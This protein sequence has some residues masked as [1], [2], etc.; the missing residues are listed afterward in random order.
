MEN[1]DIMD[2]IEILTECL[3]AGGHT[4]AS[5]CLP[6]TAVDKL[7]NA[8]RYLQAQDVPAYEVIVGNVGTV[9]SGNS[10][11]MAHAV[12]LKYVA[13]SNGGEGRAGGESVYLMERTQSGS[14]S[15]RRTFEGKADPD[16]HVPAWIQGRRPLR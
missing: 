2:A 4:M 13:I 5:W 8:I 10:Q 12:Y 14:W 16:E 11:D 1:A 6:G 7:Q 9:Y 3:R 15:F